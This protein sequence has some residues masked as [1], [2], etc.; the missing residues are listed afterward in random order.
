MSVSC[1]VKLVFIK[2]NQ[3]SGCKGLEKVENVGYWRRWPD[4]KISVVVFP[5]S[6]RAAYRRIFKNF[7]PCVSLRHVQE[8]GECVG[9]DDPPESAFF[10]VLL[11][12]IE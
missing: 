8:M 7:A 6:C 3:H 12:D 9:K 5:L 11:G 1:I 10:R 4:V 2:Y